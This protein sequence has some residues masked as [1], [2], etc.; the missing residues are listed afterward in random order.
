MWFSKVYGFLITLLI[1]FIFRC[2]YTILRL[3][4]DGQCVKSRVKIW[5]LPALQLHL[6][7]SKCPCL[8]YAMYCCSHCCINLLQ[9]N[10][11]FV[12][13]RNK[14]ILNTMESY[15]ISFYL[16]SYNSVNVYFAK[17][18]KQHFCLCIHNYNVGP[19]SIIFNI[20]LYK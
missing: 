18:I 19:I 10:F 9:Y 1:V 6:K 15:L 20:Y 4:L 2:V 8:F 7:N 14:K 5:V 12:L 11:I 16:A 3:P 17:S 13:R